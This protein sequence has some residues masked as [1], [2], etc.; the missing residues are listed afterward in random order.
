MERILIEIYPLRAYR[1]FPRIEYLNNH[2]ELKTL[3]PLI[4]FGALSPRG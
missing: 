4:I 2:T 1:L 3:L